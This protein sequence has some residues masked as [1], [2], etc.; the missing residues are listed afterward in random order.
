M[1]IVNTKTIFD[2]KIIEGYC[3]DLNKYMVIDGV[4][5]NIQISYYDNKMIIGYPLIMQSF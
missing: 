3:P 1:E 2:R 5:V 4:R